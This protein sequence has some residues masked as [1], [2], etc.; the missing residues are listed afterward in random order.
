M[1]SLYPNWNSIMGISD[2][3]R[4]YLSDTART[5][6]IQLKDVTV[7]HLKH[8]FNALS[9]I[10]KKYPPNVFE[11]HD[12][13]V[14]GSSE[15]LPGLD[16]I[17]AILTT[18]S[19]KKGS[20]VIRYQHP[21]IFAIAQQIDM[22]GLRMASLFDARR[23]IKETYNDFVAHGYPDFP[24]HAYT[25]PVCITHTPKPADKNLGRNALHALREKL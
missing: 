17:I 9:A 5:W 22:H 20:I 1:Q 14:G 6:Q 25:D 2:N 11:F 7:E 24:D 21:L 16:K 10:K 4:G 18:V 3:G 8:G 13:C 12:F 15:S 23:M 19:S